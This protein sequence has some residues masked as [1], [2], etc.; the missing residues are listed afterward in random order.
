MEISAI[1]AVGILGIAVAV[2][3]RLQLDQINRV[4]LR[5]D[6]TQGMVVLAESRIRHSDARIDALDDTVADLKLRYDD[7]HRP[8]PV[9]PAKPDTPATKR[10]A[11][12]PVAAAKKPAA[13]RAA[14]K[15]VA[16]TKK[17][18]PARKPRRTPT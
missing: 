9:A 18:A 8:Q 3:I 13:K 17:P 14:T 11:P 5:V 7:D 16:A 6:E 10:Q 4:S 15:P 1:I 2:G 12:A